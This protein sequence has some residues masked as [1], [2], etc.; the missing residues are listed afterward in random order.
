MKEIHLGLEEK[1][2]DD[3]DI[4]TGIGLKHWEYLVIDINTGS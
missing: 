3:S 2:C 4:A 1:A